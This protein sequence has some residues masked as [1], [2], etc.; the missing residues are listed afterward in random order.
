MGLLLGDV[1]RPNGENVARIWI[2]MPQIR[3]DRRKDRVE[4]SPEQLSRC[5]AA[6]EQFTQQGGV[7]TRVIGWYHSHP[8]ITVLP[9]HVDI[10]TQATYQM[11]DDG[12]V[13]LIFSTFN[14]DPKNKSQSISVTAFQSVAANEGLSPA[15]S[16]TAGRLPSL[17]AEMAQAIQLSLAEAR[18]HA[19]A[20]S[21]QWQRKGVPL[22]IV[23][24]EGPM[25]RTLTD[26]V[27]LAKVLYQEEQ[28]AFHAA[29]AESADSEG[30]INPLAA[31]Q[32]ATMYQQNLCRLMELVLAP[33][34]R[35]MQTCISQ[36]QLQK[37]FGHRGDSVYHL[38]LPTQ[39]SAAQSVAQPMAQ[40]STSMAQLLDV[41]GGVMGGLAPQASGV[42]SVGSQSWDPS[43]TLHQSLLQQQLL[44]Q[45]QAQP[46]AQSQTQPS[47]Q[48]QQQSQV[49]SVAQQ[50]TPQSLSHPSFSLPYQSQ[51]QHP[52]AQH[53]S[54]QQRLTNGSS[55]YASEHPQASTAQNVNVSIIS[56]AIWTPADRPSPQLDTAASFG[57]PTQTAQMANASAPAASHDDLAAAHSSSS[58]SS[59]I[60]P[61]SQQQLQQQLP[62]QLSEKPLELRPRPP[63]G[64]NDSRRSIA[65]N[66]QLTMHRGDSDAQ[67][68]GAARAPTGT[69]PAALSPSANSGW[70]QAQT[71]GSGI[72]QAAQGSAGPSVAGQAFLHS[73]PVL[74]SSDSTSSLTA[75]VEALQGRSSGQMPMRAGSPALG[76]RASPRPASWSSHMHDPFGELVT[77]DLKRIGSSSSSIT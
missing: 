72:Y 62:Q 74:H 71:Q 38:Q 30:N 17:D 57:A 59:S 49:H 53:V 10:K 45:S 41:P 40:L 73:Q 61:P 36:Q 23:K 20:D 21:I 18:N 65:T 77:Q 68:S 70:G 35:S 34:L 22:Q 33:M 28:K 52:P 47:Y 60:Y 54:D 14:Q 6:A 39:G 11:L 5:A 12:F 55:G 13:G 31:I 24:S 58:F 32:H 76:G 8:H 63:L 50:Q 2:A 64:G 56:P 67:S 15:P 69:S 9:S 27:A 66:T 19:S 7:R 43:A 51:L 25:E 1:T 3:S 26:I 48:M 44:L 37:Q 16:F 46:Q 42:G 29:M 4:A 75:P